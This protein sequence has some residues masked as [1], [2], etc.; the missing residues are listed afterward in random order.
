VKIRFQV[1]C[2]DKFLEGT[3]ALMVFDILDNYAYPEVM[4]QV[5]SGILQSDFKL[6]DVHLVMYAD[7]SLN[8]ILL[9]G[10][11]RSVANIKY[12]QGQQGDIEDYLGLFPS[13]SNDK[14]AAHVI[15]TKLNDM[16]Y[17]AYDLIYDRKKVRTRFELAKSFFRVAD[18][19]LQEKLFGPFV[20][21]LYSAA[22]LGIQS[23][24]LLQHNPRFSLHQTHEDT[25]KL[26]FEHAE[27]G[28]INRKLSSHYTRL[29][30]LR[31]KGR[32]LNGTHGR[33]FSISDV[34]ADNIQLLTKDLI[35][36]VGKLLEHVDFTKKLARGTYIP[37]GKS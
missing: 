11:V 36:Y 9:N 5:E 26:F 3:K 7:Q 17:C 18:Y 29:G 12:K 13:E 2:K 21:N 30:D 20:D 14:N 31:D 1:N 37:L 33:R 8:E 22:E 32:Y 28:N 34:E 27:L 15:L 6:T 4:K 10:K 35:S 23:I 25:R 19:C 24:L 16:W